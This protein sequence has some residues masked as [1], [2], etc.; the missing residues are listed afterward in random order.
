M[1]TE[2]SPGHES[3]ADH[4]PIATADDVPT[5]V[6]GAAEPVDHP[7][8]E[9]PRVVAAPLLSRVNARM[10]AAPAP[11]PT[12][13]VELVDRQEPPVPVRAIATT[14]GMVL[15]TV[16][17][18]WLVMQISQ[19]LTWILIAAFFAVALA[20]LVGG[21]Q[22]RALH[23]RAVATMVVFLVVVLA[24][25]GLIALFVIPLTSEGRTLVSQLPDLIDQINHGRGPVGDFLNRTGA[26]KYLQAHQT[27]LR[28]YVGSLTTPAVGILKGVVTGVAGAITIFVLSYLMVLEGPRFVEGSLNLFD[29]RT[30][31]RIRRVA[32]DCARSITGYISGNLL[33]SVVCGVLT[34]VVLI[35]FHVQFAVLIAVFVAVAD[36]IPM[37]GA[38]IGAIVA[39]AAAFVHSVPAGIALVVF[40]IIYQQVENHLLQP[41]IY[42]RT[43]KLNPLTVVVAILVAAEIAGILGTLL[44]IPVASMIQVV[45]RD[46]WDH[47][48][49]RPKAVPTV[50]EDEQPV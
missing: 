22:R 34:Y 15:A 30:S 23:H 19:I 1:A 36:L 2:P 46:L 50:G 16:A 25:G 24:L 13:Q 14:I 31:G 29:A 43:V 26:L 17:A 11:E 4:T 6:M 42:A 44:A 45:V 28:D 18:I 8:S 49:G 32:D 10:S 21:V 5:V 9:A 7:R 33:I 3:G 20:P 47:R 37:I 35:I 38:T 40:C 48:R 12:S 39:I 27:Q 41:V